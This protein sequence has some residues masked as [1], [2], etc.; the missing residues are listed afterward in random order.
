MGRSAGAARRPWVLAAV[1]GSGPLRMSA[2]PG[3]QWAVPAGSA[4]ASTTTRTT[5]TARSRSSAPTAATRRRTSRRRWRPSRRSPASTSSTPRTPTSPRRSRPASPRATP[6][7]SGSS[8]SPVACW[9]SPSEGN[10]QPIDTFLD[11]DAIDKTLVPGLCSTSARA[12]TGRRLRRPDAAREQEHRL[13]PEEGL[14]RRRLRGAHDA[15]GAD[16]PRRPDQGRRHHPVVHGLER[17][18]G[19]RLGRHR[20]DRAVRA[21]AQ[22]ARRLQR[23]DQPRDPVRRPADRRGVRRVRQDRQDRRQGATAACRRVVNTQV[24]ESMV[25]AFRNPPEC[26]LERQGNFEISFLPADDPG[27]PRQRGRRLRRSRPSR[28]APTAPPILGGADLAALFN[29]N[30]EDAIEVMQFL[31]SDKFGAEWAQAGGWLSPHKTFD[32]QQLPE[33]DDQGHRRAARPTPP[34]VVFDGSDVMPKEVGSGTFWT[35]MVELD[36]GQELAGHHGC[37]RGELARE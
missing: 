3:R 6:P 17:R 34:T 13:V 16:R 18:P 20:L 30:D 12:R 25:P 5:A 24:A 4:A 33:P 2:G 32:A 31:T 26:M 15:R 36:P 10:I 35:G 23:V 1:T 21:D 11:Y 29:G 7:T 9:S 14:G 22:R 37:D 28:P 19:D 8:R 27:R